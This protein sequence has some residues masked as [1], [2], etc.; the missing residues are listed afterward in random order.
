ML[1]KYGAKEE[2]S[3]RGVS[4][5]TEKEKGLFSEVFKRAKSRLVRISCS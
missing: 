2:A 4:K 1:R 3:V 5:S